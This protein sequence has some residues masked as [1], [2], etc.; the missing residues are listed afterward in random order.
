M[1]A[2]ESRI[3]DRFLGKNVDINTPLYRE[4]NS[5]LEKNASCKREA[6]R[7]SEKLSNYSERMKG[8][9]LNL[10]YVQRYFE[11]LQLKKTILLEESL[12]EVF[13]MFFSEDDSVMASAVISINDEK[14]FS[15]GEGNFVPFEAINENVELGT[16]Q[17]KTS[18][19]FNEKKYYDLKQ[20]EIL[21]FSI[22]CRY[23]LYLFVMKN[24]EY[25]NEFNSTKNF[26]LFSDLVS[27]EIHRAN[28]Y[29]LKGVLAYFVLKNHEE[30]LDRY[31][32]DILL[33]INDSISAVLRDGIRKS[34]ILGTYK[35]GFFLVYFYNF[36][37][38][39]AEGKIRWIVDRINAEEKIRQLNIAIELK[40]GFSCIGKNT[41]NF[42][43]V[44]G[45]ILIEIEEDNEE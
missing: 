33:L 11:E 38:E 23:L 5:L 44:F 41:K 19:V 9:K 22:F 1:L 4:I 34:D 32:E 40:K 35:E 2:C 20:T 45:K 24:D 7:F 13:R 21:L 18:I 29:D 31:G 12:L 15:Y 27:K 30:I 3:P 37:Y 28:R 25:M 17:I 26:R 16:Y 14:I 43:T 36:D 42:D 6:N 8:L 10:E 39:T